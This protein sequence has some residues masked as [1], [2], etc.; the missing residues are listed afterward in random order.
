MLAIEAHMKAIGEA[1][2]SCGVAYKE[3]AEAMELVSKSI[4]E[5]IRQV[6]NQVATDIEKRSHKIVLREKGIQKFP[7]IPVKKRRYSPRT[8]RL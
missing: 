1:L 4:P 3:L 8:K 5:D 7:S 2:K 6:V